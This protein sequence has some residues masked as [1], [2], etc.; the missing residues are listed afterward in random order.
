MSSFEVLV[1][2]I[3]TLGVDAIVNPANAR[4]APGEGLTGRSGTRQ[5]QS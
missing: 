3:E 5:G 2:R 1:G 4:L